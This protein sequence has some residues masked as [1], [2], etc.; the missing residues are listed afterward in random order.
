MKISIIIDYFNV[1]IFI[2]N[3]NSTIHDAEILLGDTS[4]D[5]IKLRYQV[6]KI[7]DSE[8]LALKIEEIF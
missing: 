7:L 2:N 3:Y 1:S 8:L 5:S 4:Y 6:K